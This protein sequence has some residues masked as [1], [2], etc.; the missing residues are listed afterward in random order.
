M[1]SM[2]T[3][4]SYNNFSPVTAEETALRQCLH[5]AVET[6]VAAYMAA[7]KRQ[8]IVEIEIFPTPQ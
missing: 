8:D 5:A 1:E 6:A 3:A 2:M 7:S 4:V